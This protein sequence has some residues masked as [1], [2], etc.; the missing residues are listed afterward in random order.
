M[1][2]AILTVAMFGAA[3]V[4]GLTEP[5]VASFLEP[6]REHAHLVGVQVPVPV[7]RELGALVT[8]LCLHRLDRRAVRDEKARTAYDGAN[9]GRSV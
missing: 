3:K 5:T 1:D 7:E 2:S 9:E 8:E 4:G 6:F